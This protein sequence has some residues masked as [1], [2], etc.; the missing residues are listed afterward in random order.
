MAK[1]MT[2]CVA[3]M[4]CFFCQGCTIHFKATELELD[5]K[6]DP[7]IKNVTYELEKIDILRGEAS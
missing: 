6:V 4:L 2:V 1:M 7:N 5:T 3:L